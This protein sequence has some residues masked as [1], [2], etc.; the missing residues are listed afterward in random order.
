MRR[1]ARGYYPSPAVLAEVQQASRTRPLLMAGIALSY[2][3]SIVVASAFG[4]YLWFWAPL[5]VALTA[6]IL[7]LIF[8][9]QQIRALELLV[10]D[11][12]HK[13]WWRASLV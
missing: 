6:H 3:T 13:N 9:A 4:A 10:H 7:L 2:L 12:G 1:W 8:N 11:G 5:P